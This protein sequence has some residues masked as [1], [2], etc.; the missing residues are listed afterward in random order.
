M[1]KPAIFH[2]IVESML[3]VLE[4]L[5]AL[6]YRYCVFSRQKGKISDSKLTKIITIKKNTE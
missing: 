4:Y 3:L 1:A 5:R 2:E 6:I